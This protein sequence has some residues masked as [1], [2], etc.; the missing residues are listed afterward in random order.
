MNWIINKVLDDTAHALQDLIENYKIKIYNKVCLHRN[1]SYVSIDFPE[2]LFNTTYSNYVPHEVI[3]K[4]NYALGPHMIGVLVG[5][6][7]F[8]S[9]SMRLYKIYAIYVQSLKNY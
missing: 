6:N 1:T 4:P 5:N 8:L 9:D 3:I 2:Q 7:I